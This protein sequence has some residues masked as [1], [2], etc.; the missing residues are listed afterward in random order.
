[1]QGK[2][3]KAV[4]GF[5]YVHIA[6]SGV[7]ECRA[8]GVFR[9]N[10]IKPLV[11]DDVEISV[12]DSLE[13]KGNVE[14]VLSRK[15]ALIRPAVANVDMALV[16][17]AAA[18][19]VPNLNLLDRFLILMQRQDVPVTICFNKM[20]LVDG[21]E[22]KR[23]SDIYEK[24]G[25]PVLFTSAGQKTG[26]DALCGALEGKTST[27]AGP[28]GVGK[29]SL[30]NLLQ[31][32]AVMETGELSRRI[33]RGRQTTRHT[34]L[35]HMQGV[36][37]IVDTPGFS[38]LFLPE[39]DK[40]ELGQYYPEFALYEPGCRFCG[41]SHISEPDCMVRQALSEGKISSVRYDNYCQLYQELKERRK[42]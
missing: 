31:P 16:I 15:N 35:L 2:I 9:K 37:Y 22:R 28:S 18:C 6:E 29:S 27:V 12:T 38:S 8:R 7:Y 41:C 11:G 39:M 5:Y 23:L 36:T 26:I 33:E 25:Y 1:M 21:A 14:R 17:F 13:K 3:L 34:Q 30:V 40:E 19:P 42:Y 10:N 32:E 4:S 20:E 24:C